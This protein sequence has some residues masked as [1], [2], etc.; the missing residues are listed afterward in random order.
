MTTLRLL[1]GVVVT[2]DLEL[3]QLDIKTTFLHR[4]L[5]EDIYMSQPAGF[6]ASGEKSHL[7]CRLK[8]S[9]YGLK[10]APR[11]WY[12]KFDSYIRQLGYT[13]PIP[14]HACRVGN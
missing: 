4:D 2:E 7:V 6:S 10:Q 9:I 5:E 1:L 14:T 8:K 3:E 13:N 12:Q 11:M